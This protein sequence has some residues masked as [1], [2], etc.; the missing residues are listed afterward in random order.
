MSI[1]SKILN[2][3]AG[4]KAIHYREK[5]M[6]EITT[7]QETLNV[8]KTA[9][10]KH[11]NAVPCDLCGELMKNIKGH[12]KNIKEQETKKK[13]DTYRISSNRRNLPSHFGSEKFSNRIERN[14]LMTE[15]S[16]F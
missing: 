16:Y 4:E 14:L 15:L 11:A 13:R 10:S 3:N 1:K 6:T 5:A 12:R 8:V 7:S 9:L 2:L